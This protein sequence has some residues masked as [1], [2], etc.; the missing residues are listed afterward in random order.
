MLR[1]ME[2]LAGWRRRHPR[3]MDVLLVV[4]VAV[5]PVIREQ[6]GWRPVWAQL[7]VYTALVLPLL[8]RRRYPVVAAALVTA[9]FWAQYLGEVWGR[10]PGRGALAMAAVFY[11]LSVRGLCRAAIATALCAGTCVLV[12][13]P[14]WVADHPRA[15]AGGD[16]WLT[17]LSVVLWLTGA[18]TFGAYVRARRAYLAEFAR[19]AELAEAQRL[20]LARAAVAE[21][22]TRIAREIHDV[23]AHGITVMVLNAEGARLAHPTDPSAPD[24]A[25]RTIGATGRAALRELRGLLDVLRADDPTGRTGDAERAGDRRVRA[26]GTTGRG[27]ALDDL[28]VL[29]EGLRAD[30]RLELTGERDGVS[31]A[32]IEQTYRIVQE[33]LT[34]VVKHASPDAAT[35][36]RVDLGDPGP[37]RRVRIRV[38]NAV[39]TGA[40]PPALPVSAGQGLVGMRERAALY[41]GTVEAGRLPDGGYRVDACLWLT[42]CRPAAVNR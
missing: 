2:S 23:L 31:A 22:R 13:I 5:P 27:L 30:C 25:L 42:P 12:W 28:R 32:V 16:A 10:E 38:D 29:V 35:R 20:A 21:E 17:P 39:G 4:F 33:A 24:R 37:E 19:R 14:G 34:N 18:W 8:F 41:G 7:T 15:G 36:V 1:L 9:A 26:G 40:A 6:P 3:Q 11:T